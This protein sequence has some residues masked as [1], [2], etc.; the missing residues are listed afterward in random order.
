MLVGHTTPSHCHTA[1]CEVI[2]WLLP[3]FFF[4]N[5]WSA[6]WYAWGLFPFKEIVTADL[7]LRIR[8]RASRRPCARL[9]CQLLKLYSH[10]YCECDCLIFLGC[11]R[12]CAYSTSKRLEGPKITQLNFQYIFIFKFLS[13]E[14]GCRLHTEVQEF[15][16][17]HTGS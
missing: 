2:P 17:G 12:T 8:I 3:L 7:D 16:I 1:L 15:L 13:S 9:S 6:G 4:F 5:R 10:V 11:L 14:L